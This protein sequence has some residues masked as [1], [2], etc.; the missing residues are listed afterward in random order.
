VLAGQWCCFF[1]V[2]EQ[3][4]TDLLPAQS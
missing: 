1:G 4:V 2:V 3:T